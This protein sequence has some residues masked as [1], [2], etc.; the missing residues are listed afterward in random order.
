MAKHRPRPTHHIEIPQYAYALAI[1]SGGLAY[2]VSQLVRPTTSW[3]G[4]AL[5]AALFAFIWPHKA[6]QWGVWM[7][8]P[9]ALLICFDVVATGNLVGVLLGS[10]ITFAKALSFA[11]LGA[12][13][14]AKIPLHGIAHRRRL[15]S[16]SNGAQDSSVLKKRSASQVSVAAEASSHHNENSL[17]SLEAI[18][19]L[20]SES[21]ALIAATQEGDLERVKLLISDG[22]DVNAQSKN[23]WTPFSL[24][25]QGFDLEMVKA[26]FGKRGS[27]VAANGHGWTPLIVA[28]ISGHTEV[29]RALLAHGAEV[30][31][32]NE[33]GWTALRFAVSM[34]ETHILR[35]LLNAGADANR[36]DREGQTALMQAARENSLETLEILLESGADVLIID[37]HQQTALKVAQAHGHTEIVNLLEESEAKVSHKIEVASHNV[38]RRPA[39]LLVLAA[40]F[41]LSLTVTIF[42]LGRYSVFPTTFDSNGI[43]TSFAAD[44]IQYREDAI[45]LSEALKHG[46]IL[47]WL[48][49]H[50]SFQVKLYSVSFALFGSLLG[51]NIIGIELLNCLYYL[52]TLALVF[53]IGREAFTERVGLVSAVTVALWPSFLLHTTQMLR[54][55]LFVVG[56]LTLF[57]VLLRLTSSARTYSWP[58]ALLAGGGGGLVFVVLWIAR[59]NMGEILVATVIMGALMLIARQFARSERIQIANLCGMTLLVA[60]TIGAPKVLPNYYQPV[61]AQPSL[62]AEAHAEASSQSVWSRLVAQV[63]V[64]RHRFIWKYPNAGSNLDT[65]VQLVTTTD[66]IRYFPRASVIGFFAPF[67]NIW[68]TIGTQVGLSGRMLA[69]IETFIIY[70]VEA[71]ALYALW[72][73]RRQLSAWFLFLTATTGIIALGFVVVNI[74]ALFRLRYLF[75][76]LL[77]ILGTDGVLNAFDRLS[78]RLM[79]AKVSRALG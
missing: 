19:Q 20:N 27:T 74:G 30:N 23:G 32:E 53:Q 25:G 9:A 44:G 46:Q 41:H 1:L 47:N 5:L 63:S 58:K 24:D 54:D 29:V 15:K 10:G 51:Q 16:P 77:V 70:I 4:Y 56:T 67:P 7:C 26:I 79:V 35:L 75:L 34:G 17:P 36:R 14:G 76:I 66:L 8:L 52:M 38:W 3:L 49:S 42:L 73:R 50:D 2:V 62:S 22:A 60:L 37:R 55:P 21:A 64:A 11:C 72:Q 31:V 12:Y 18:A 28:T 57:L 33:E 69:G 78:K 6:L 68:F 13:L 59:S 45:R 40:L 43:G 39:R 65:N 48:S 71:F 61:Y